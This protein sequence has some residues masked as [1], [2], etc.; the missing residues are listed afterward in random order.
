MIQSGCYTSWKAKPGSRRDCPVKIHFFPGGEKK[1]KNVW[2]PSC[3]MSSKWKDAFSSDALLKKSV[4]S[5]KLH[6][7]WSVC[8]SSSQSLA[9]PPCILFFVMWCEALVRFG[10]GGP[11]GGLFHTAFFLPPAPA[12]WCRGSFCFSKPRLF[13]LV[14]LAP[15]SLFFFSSNICICSILPLVLVRSRGKKK[16]F[17]LCQYHVAFALH[18]K[19]LCSVLLWTK[20]PGGLQSMDSQ[21][22]WT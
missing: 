9:H 3:L 19:G 15:Q 12:G 8:F 21:K 4:L 1:G 13:F 2:E 14:L 7:A 6:S 18:V 22:S 11:D 20:E 5:A 17:S 16:F 10:K